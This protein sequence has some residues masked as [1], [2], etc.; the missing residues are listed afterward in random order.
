MPPPLTWRRQAIARDSSVM[1]VGPFRALRLWRNGRGVAAVE[2]S[3]ILAVALLIMGLVVYGGQI[4]RVERKGDFSPSRRIGRN[5][6]LDDAGRMDRV[7]GGPA[8]WL[9]QCHYCRLQSRM[10]R[11]PNASIMPAE[12]Q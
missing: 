2:F 11:A 7:D 10:R 5:Q 1:S 8:R 6:S 12:A 3:L 9:G 4:Y